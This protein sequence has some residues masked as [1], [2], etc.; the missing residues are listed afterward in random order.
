M[1]LI[2]V[3]GG[4]LFIFIISSIFEGGFGGG[5]KAGDAV[6]R[7]DDQAISYEEFNRSMERMSRQAAGRMSDTQISNSVFESEVRRALLGEIFEELGFSVEADQ[8]ADYVEQAGWHRSVPEF[9]DEQG[10]FDRNNFLNTIFDWKENDPARYEAWQEDEKQIVFL[11]KD[12][13]LQNLVKAGMTASLEEGIFNYHTENDKVEIEFLRVPYTSVPDSTIAV[14]KDEIAAYVKE[15]ADDF[16]QEDARNIRYVYFELKPSE[17]DKKRAEERFL[18]LLNDTSIPQDNF[19]LTTDLDAFFGNYSDQPL[20]TLPKTKAQLPSQ[21]QDT[22]ESMEVGQVF[23]PYQDGDTFNAIRLIGKEK[24]G[25]VRA[26]HVLIAYEGAQRANPD[27]TRTKED[28]RIKAEGV[29]AEARKS[30]ADFAKLAEDNSD[31]PTASRGGDLGFFQKD[32]GMAQEFQDFCFSNPTGAIGLVETDFGFHVIKVEEKQDLF[33]VARLVKEVIPSE[34][35]E[36]SI[37]NDAVKFEKEVLEADA[38]RFADIAAQSSYQVRPVNKMK[39]MDEVLPGLGARRQIVRWAFNK[40]TSVGEIQKFE[41]PEGYVIVQMTKEFE[42][43]TMSVEEASAKAR[44]E[45]LKARK[46]KMLMEKY[47][48]MDMLE[49]AKEANVP[50]SKSSAL[51]LSAPTL[52]GAGREPA[53][54]GE[55]FA[56]EEGATSGLI[57]GETGIFMVKLLDFNEAIKLPNFAPFSTTKSRTRLNRVASNFYNSIKEGAEIED[58]RAEF[59]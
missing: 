50:V 31:G 56:L 13:M 46:A 44:P 45:I 39:A 25:N 8:I 55:A 28:A 16:K 52:P 19:A 23:G 32:R 54:V 15:H 18:A 26:R 36:N 14:S 42:E 21:V 17:A 6:V 33:Q 40:E 34:E 7:V 5:S 37:F 57:E 53:V 10:N 29:L 3:I 30:G 1:L 4:A 11:S 2:I 58:R 24:D 27:I 9:A 12:R 41:L 49:I 47:V 35:T 51:T 43:G 48:G 38:D 20:D 59:F 22:I